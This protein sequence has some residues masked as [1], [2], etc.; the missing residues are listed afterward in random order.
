MTNTIKIGQRITTAIYGREVSAIVVAI[1]P[2]GT[3]DV[4]TENGYFRV[5]GF[6]LN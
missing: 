6:S 1:Y 3:I 2:H 4:K 5:S